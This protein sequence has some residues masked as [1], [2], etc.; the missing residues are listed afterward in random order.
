MAGIPT[1]TTRVAPPN[2]SIFEKNGFRA[3]ITFTLDTNISLW[4]V[5]VTPPGIDGG[6]PVLLG[7]MWWSKFEPKVPKGLAVQTEARGIVQYS[8]G[9]LQSIINA[10]NRPDEICYTFPSGRTWSFYGYLRQF[11]PQEHRDGVACLAQIVIE[12]TTLDGSA[13]GTN[14]TALEQRPRAYLTSASLSAEVI[15]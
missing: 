13:D 8:V 1:P 7:N 5:A 4:E 14:W 15:E 10:I 12:P 3:L 9:A 6:P 11:M 2:A